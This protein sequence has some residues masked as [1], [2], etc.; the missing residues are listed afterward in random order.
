[1]N[2]QR[3]LL[4]TQETQQSNKNQMSLYLTYAATLVLM[5]SCAY[6][7]YRAYN[8][9]PAQEQKPREY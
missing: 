8:K 5:V 9:K 2:I 6:L 1:M 4:H 7:I 3:N